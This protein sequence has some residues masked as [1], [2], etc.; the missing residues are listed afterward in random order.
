MRHIL[1][2]HTRTRVN[3]TKSMNQMHLAS[4][5]IEYSLLIQKYY[6]YESITN[7][8]CHGSICHMARTSKSS[9]NQCLS[10]QMA[11]P[12]LSAYQQRWRSADAVWIYFPRDV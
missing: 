9:I 10:L 5:D 6:H 3:F 4:V 2:T 1:K 8:I 11:E 7:Q 12:S